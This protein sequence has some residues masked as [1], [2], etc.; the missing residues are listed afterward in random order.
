MVK[1]CKRCGIE[2]PLS[3][4]Y[5]RGSSKDGRENTCIACRREK[6]SE[7]DRKRYNSFA[8]RESHLIRTYAITQA[9][10]QHLLLMQDGCCAICGS[11]SNGRSV[12]EFFVVD[13]CHKTDEVR[14]LLCH[15]CNAAL[16]LLKD[17]VTSLQN[18]ITY[19]SKPT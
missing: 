1:S 18:A 14:G 11:T 12:D 2:K 10:Y 9:V 5:K 19:L 16:G 8:R 4:F 17:N 13:H 7:A 6:M 3:D 15:P